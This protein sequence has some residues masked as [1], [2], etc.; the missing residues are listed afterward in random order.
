MQV[1]TTALEAQR[2]PA[3]VARQVVEVVAGLVEAD[4]AARD[5]HGSA[6]PARGGA[7]AS[8]TGAG[9]GA[10]AAE[11]EAAAQMVQA[12]AALVDAVLASAE[13]VTETTAVAATNLISNLMGQMDGEPLAVGAGATADG[14]ASATTAEKLRAALA[15]LSVKVLD[16]LQARTPCEVPRNREHF[17]PH[18]VR[19]ISSR[20]RLSSP[21]PPRAAA[22]GG[23]KQQQ[24]RAAQPVREPDARGAQ[25]GCTRATDHV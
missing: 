23:R 25:R 17:P 12:A 13:Q 18:D 9:G 10:A 19:S 14:G 8:G 15:T 7:G 20:S 22:A 6:D 11:Q 21:P 3:G 5:A 4:A 16:Q 1:L 24:G 2:V